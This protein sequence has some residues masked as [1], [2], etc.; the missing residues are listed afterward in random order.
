[1]VRRLIAVGVIFVC[2][3]IAWGILGGAVFTRTYLQ[4][5]DLVKKV[6]KLWGSK[7]SQKPL[8]VT[9]W[10]NRRRR[11]DEI[12]DMPILGS[13]IKVKLNLEH[14]QKGL[15]WYPT[16]RADYQ[17]RYQFKNNTGADRM[18]LVKFPFPNRSGIY[19]DFSLSL[20]GKKTWSKNPEPGSYETSGKVKLKQGE[21]LEVLISYNSQGMEIWRYSFGGVSNIKNFSLVMDTDFDDIDFPDETMSPVK[22]VKTPA[23][24][25]LTWNYNN[26]VS[27]VGIGMQLPNLL[28]PGPMAGRISLFA[29]ISLFFFTMMVLV[30]ALLQ[31][32]SLH[33]MHFFFLSAAFFAFHLLVAYL[34]DHLSIHLSFAIASV[35]SLALVTSYLKRAVDGS[36][37]LM[38]GGVQLVYLVLFSYTFFFKGYTGLTITIGAVLSLLVQ[39]QLTAKIDWEDV[40]KGKDKQG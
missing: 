11:T 37:A 7:L 1:M 33:P 39:M 3:S 8:R 9:Y 30:V 27:G 15:L 19:N 24:W 14:R 25:Q 31:G 17:A 10:K 40:F 38:A 28:Q 5:K 35:V 13:D 36:F 20:G 22:K 32:K 23:G 12:L 2:V 29:P 18:F 16:Y 4:D 21:S 6:G 34:V 26:L